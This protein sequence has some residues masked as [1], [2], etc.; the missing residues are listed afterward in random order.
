[1]IRKAVEKPANPY[2]EFLFTLLLELIALFDLVGD[3]YLVCSMYTYGHTAWFTLSIATMLWPFYVSYVPLVTFQKKRG[4]IQDESKFLKFLNI[5]SMTPLIVGYLLFMD[6][7]YIFVSVVVTPIAFL[8]KHLT[9]G[10][11]NVTNIEERLDGLYKILFGMSDMDIK[12]FRRL[13]TISQLSFE[14]FPQV[15]LQMRI[16]I[17]AY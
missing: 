12:G 11:L 17:F 4:K 5:V 14:S 8:L 10:Y 9:C 15:L 13:R 7:F 3:I 1:M 6:I 2:F 16:L